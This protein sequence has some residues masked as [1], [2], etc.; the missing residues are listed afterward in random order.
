MDLGLSRTWG[1]CFWKKDLCFPQHCYKHLGRIWEY[2]V[3]WHSLGGFQNR[4][5]PVSMRMEKMSP[6]QQILMPRRVYPQLCISLWNV[7]GT[8]EVL[9]LFVLLSALY[10]YLQSFHILDIK[11]TLYSWCLWESFISQTTPWGHT[12]PIHHNMR[13]NIAEWSDGVCLI[14]ECSTQLTTLT[15]LVRSLNRNKQN[16]QK[17][18]CTYGE[19][20]GKKCQKG[21]LHFFHWGWFFPCLVLWKSCLHHPLC[22]MDQG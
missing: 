19:D 9:L 8:W 1:L 22:L 11:E 12:Q 7:G 18:G 20:N 4:G 2:F 21:N 14:Q 10:S 6:A 16:N 3:V 13:R 17:C 15:H 5:A